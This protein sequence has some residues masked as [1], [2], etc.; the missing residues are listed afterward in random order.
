MPE[1]ADQSD[2][3]NKLKQFLYPLSRSYGE[4]TPDHL[5]LNAN[6]QEFAQRVGYLVAL[7]AG[8]KLYIE[9]AYAEIRKLWKQLKRSKKQLEGPKEPPQ[10]S[11]GSDG[12]LE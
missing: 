7:E 2:E 5:L 1:E 11:Q 4:F 9:E 3:T 8:G 12:N 10:Q 6:L